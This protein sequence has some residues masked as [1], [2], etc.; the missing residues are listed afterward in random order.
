MSAGRSGVELRAAAAGTF[1]GS[2]PRGLDEGAK[3]RLVPRALGGQVLRVPLHTDPPP[4]IGRLEALDHAVRRA[5]CDRETDR[6]L[7]HRLVME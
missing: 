1:S 6:R 4:S 3:Q 5:R 7:L 2:S